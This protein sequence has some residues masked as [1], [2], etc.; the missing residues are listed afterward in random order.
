MF[1]VTCH[2]GNRVL[3]SARNYTQANNVGC[4]ELCVNRVATNQLLRKVISSDA[5]E[6]VE[7]YSVRGVTGTLYDYRDL[8]PIQS[9]NLGA[10]LE[11]H[12]QG[13]DS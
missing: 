4:H 6:T 5:I 10:D 11:A 3:N 8:T 13:F 2:K 9:I 12:I 1:G 7:E